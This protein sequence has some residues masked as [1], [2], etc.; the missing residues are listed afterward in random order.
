MTREEL[1][2]LRE[3]TAAVLAL[4]AALLGHA[5][6]VQPTEPEDLAALAVAKARRNLSGQGVRSK[7]VRVR[8]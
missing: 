6:P 3:N 4:T 8:A 5:L 2:A 1:Q 7:S